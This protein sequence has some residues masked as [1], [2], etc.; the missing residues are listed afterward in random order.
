M[1]NDKLKN[2]IILL[3]IV[4]I[5]ILSVLVGLF[6]TNKISLNSSSNND[7]GTINENENNEVKEENTDIVGRYQ[8]IIQYAEGPAYQ[9]YEFELN[10]D[11]TVNYVIG[12]S[13]T[14]NHSNASA[15]MNYSG[16]YLEKDNEVI[17]SIVSTD[18][19]CEPGKYACID[20]ITL[21][22][23]NNG[24]LGY[25]EESDSSIQDFNKVDSLL[26]VK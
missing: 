24:T 9:I 17:L 1:K 11:N 25:E 22:K 3:L 20:I 18:D 5:I 12:G 2:I 4:I 14:E 16:T 19:N 13:S 7:D 26:L 15:V 8:K 23:Q 21:S 10:S 6:A